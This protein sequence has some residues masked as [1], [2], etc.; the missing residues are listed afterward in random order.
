M[1]YTFRTTPDGISLV[2]LESW[3]WPQGLEDPRGHLMNEGL[4]LGLERKVL[5]FS[6]RDSGHVVAVCVCFYNSASLSFSRHCYT[7]ELAKR[8]TSSFS[9]SFNL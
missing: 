3:P 8:S 2:V 6:P 7:E 1:H 9:K 5:A 4:G